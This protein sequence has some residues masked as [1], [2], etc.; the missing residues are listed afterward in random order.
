MSLEAV[1]TKIDEDIIR[2]GWSTIGVFGTGE[3][4]IVPFA[5]SVGFTELDQPE[6]IVYGLPAEMAHG[7]I[8]CVYDAIKA[9]EQLKDGAELGK[10]LKEPYKVW[11]RAVPGDGSPANAARARYESVRLVQIVWPDRVGNYPWEDGYE[12]AC[13]QPVLAD[14]PDLIDD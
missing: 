5:Y 1:L 8:G 10:I 9:G 12:A 11:V 3:D 2:H 6:V 4:P 13:T 14:R 7:I